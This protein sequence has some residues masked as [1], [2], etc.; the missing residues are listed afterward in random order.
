MLKY[1]I[2]IDKNQESECV[3]Y[4]HYKGVDDHHNGLFIVQ[5]GSLNSWRICQINQK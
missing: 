4:Q 2:R 5:K 1:E 3:N